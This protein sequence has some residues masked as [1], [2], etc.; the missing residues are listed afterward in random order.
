MGENF[1]PR[2]QGP[3]VEAFADDVRTELVGG[4]LQ[5][6]DVVN[7]KE[8][9]VVF[10]EADLRPGQLPLDEAV[11]VEIVGGLKREERG[12]PHHHRAEDLIADVK[13]V[14]REAAAMLLKT[15]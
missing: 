8:G 10:A 5:R 6:C 11:A 9:V 1:G 14:V 13:V 3:V 2:D 4:G 7:G 15:K 12:R